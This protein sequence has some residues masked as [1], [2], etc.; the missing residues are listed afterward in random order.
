M[1]IFFVLER[2]FFYWILLISHLV[3]TGSS[4]KF[5]CDWNSVQGHLICVFSHV[6]LNLILI[7]FFGCWNQPLDLR[8]LCFGSKTLTFSSLKFPLKK[9]CKQEILVITSSL[10]TSKIFPLFIIY[11]GR[12]LENL[13]NLCQFLLKSPKFL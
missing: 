10:D 13:L 5:F 3:L 9:L 6:I 4:F 7:S 1:S 12:S 11:I 8:F 2:I